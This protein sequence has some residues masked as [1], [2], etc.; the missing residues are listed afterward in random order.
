MLVAAEVAV[1]AEMEPGHVGAG[2]DEQDHFPLEGGIE[3]VGGGAGDEH[4]EAGDGG[5]G[6]GAP[7]PGD[8]F[9]RQV[10]DRVAHGGQAEQAQVDE[11]DRADHH[12][13][14]DD[15]DRFDEGEQPGAADFPTQRPVL[16]VDPEWGSQE[17]GKHS[18]RPHAGK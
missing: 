13:D 15:V 6:E 12:G 11:Q 10:A 17:I 8:E 1:D 7:G 18:V 3:D 2:E 4:A 16:D 9:P 5:D 14:G